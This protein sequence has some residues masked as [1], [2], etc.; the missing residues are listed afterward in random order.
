VNLVLIDSAATL[1]LEAG[2]NI[3]PTGLESRV[4]GSEVRK[5]AAAAA[6]GGAA[7]RTRIPKKNRVAEGGETS[8]GGPGLKLS[9]LRGLPRLEPAES[10]GSESSKTA[11]VQRLQPGICSGSMAG[12]SWNAHETGLQEAWA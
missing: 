11:W 8:A 6:R 5:L 1:V 2:A 4:L 3:G 12:D 10:S 9:Q 7:V